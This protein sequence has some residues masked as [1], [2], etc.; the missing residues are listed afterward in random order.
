MSQESLVSIIIPCKE[1]DNYTRECIEYCKRLDYSNF[2]II[3]LPD[4]FPQTINGV[5]VIPTGSVS[6]G[7]KRNKGVETAKGEFCAF[8]DN[9]A[10]PRSDWL[11]NA[12]SILKDQR[13]GGVGGPG[14]TPEEDGI[15]Q[16]AGGY[17]LSSF[18][19][20]ALSSRYK[21][22]SS[23]ESEDIHSCNFI[24]R[25]AVIKEAGGWN[26]KY[27]PG[28]DTLM[29]LAI[30]KLGKKLIESSEIVVY[31]H[32]RSL[33]KPHLKQVSRFGEHRGFFVKKFPQNSVRL[34]YFLPSLLVLSFVI[35]IFVSL[36]FPIFTFVMLFG[37]IFYLSLSL[38]A[39][40]SQVKKLRFVLSIWLGIIATH[41]IYG[42][43]FLSGL[44][45]REL[46]R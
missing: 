21:T 4:T 17:V 37:T 30:R 33:F 7:V 32:R 28:E 10:Y 1:V 44:A 6:P 40:A 22:K 27:W 46:K 2:E 45:K 15:M 20:G 18:M 42:C 29:C 31:H 39:A 41:L 11:T 24:S 43:F 26:E 35:G 34:T 12:L 14:L 8:V 3:L 16:K 9:D 5:K 19:V 25:K 38:A 36:F 13:V 23:V